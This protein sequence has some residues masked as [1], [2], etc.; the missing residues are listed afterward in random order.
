MSLADCFFLVEP[1]RLWGTLDNIRA[2]K[3]MGGGL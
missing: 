2:R 3:T 1:L